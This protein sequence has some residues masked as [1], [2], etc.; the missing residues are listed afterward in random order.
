MNLSQK[1][2]AERQKEIINKCKSMSSLESRL[3]KESHNTDM[4]SNQLFA[5]EELV[6]K[7]CL[8]MFGSY[9]L[10]LNIKMANDTT[11][12]LNLGRIQ[13]INFIIVKKLEI[14]EDWLLEKKVEFSA[15]FFDNLKNLEKIGKL[16]YNSLK[17]L[18]S[19]IFFRVFEDT[20]FKDLKL[21][22]CQFWVPFY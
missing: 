13:N 6:L 18:G 19:I 21:K 22:A 1:L 17:K 4:V 10:P 11:A 15:E 2:L 5:Q 3:N 12:L 7:M 8:N 9:Y 20:N 14:R 16:N